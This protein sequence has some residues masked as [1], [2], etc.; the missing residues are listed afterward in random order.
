MKKLFIFFVIIC[1]ASC[2]PE[3]SIPN[4]PDETPGASDAI[5]YAGYPLYALQ[6][7]EDG[8]YRISYYL[9]DNTIEVYY[10]VSPSNIIIERGKSSNVA[11][12]QLNNGL[13]TGR[14]VVYLTNDYLIKNFYN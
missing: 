7:N 8:T 5:T 2:A 11:F 10:S 4:L 12:K 6:I 1:F 14:F 13:A 3:V 9:S